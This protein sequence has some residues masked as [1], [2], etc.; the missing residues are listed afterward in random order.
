M[1]D[2]QT[3]TDDELLQDLLMEKI[4]EAYQRRQQ[5]NGEHDSN[6]INKTRAKMDLDFTQA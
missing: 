3:Q 5:E 6:K 2:S 4:M 1:V